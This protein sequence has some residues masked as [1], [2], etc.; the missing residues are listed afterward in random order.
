M[1]SLN[2]LRE[3]LKRKFPG[4]QTS[5]LAAMLASASEK[6]I[7]SYEEVDCDEETKRS[8]LLSAYKERLLLPVKT[9]KNLLSLA[10]QDRILNAKPGETYEMPNVIRHPINHAKETSEWKPELAVKKYLEEIAEPDADKMLTVFNEIRREIISQK[11]PH[12]IVKITPHMIKQAAEKHGLKVNM[13]KLIVEFKGGGIINPHINNPN[14][15]KERITYEVNP[16][17]IK[18]RF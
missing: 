1:E 9:S 16:S 3:V 5:L 12:T 6:G 17:L 7:I 15:T 13:N 10:W 14:S 11:D 8:L 2:R 18:P 4:E